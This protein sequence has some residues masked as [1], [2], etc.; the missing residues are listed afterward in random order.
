MRT[1]LRDLRAGERGTVTGYAGDSQRFRARLLAM[2][3]TPGCEVTVLRVAPLGDPMEVRVR[4]YLLSV[5]KA[6]AATIS[7]EKS[8]M[9]R[10]AP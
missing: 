10:V 3:L 5:R 9:E 1:S 8:S 2:G 7:I 4:G 6:E